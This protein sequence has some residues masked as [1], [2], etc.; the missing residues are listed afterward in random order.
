MTTHTIEADRADYAAFLA[1]HCMLIE[2][3]GGRVDRVPLTEEIVRRIVD[4]RA[5]HQDLPP[6]FDAAVVAPSSLEGCGMFATRDMESGQHIGPASINGGRTVL[7]R[8]TNH[9]KC[10]NCV[11]LATPGGKLEMFT[12]CKVKQ[13]EELTI[14]YREAVRANPASGVRCIAAANEEEGNACL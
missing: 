13:W 1:E 3:E 7:G 12:R 2:G 5:D 8:M 4:Y 10:P 6:E 9:A 14:D 11:F